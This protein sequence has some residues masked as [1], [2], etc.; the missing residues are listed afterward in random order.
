MNTSMTT[1]GDPSPFRF[2][3]L[4]VATGLAATA[5]VAG[6][7]CATGTA[8]AAPA[9]EPDVVTIVA[10]DRSGYVSVPCFGPRHSFDQDIAGP[11]PTC[12][13]RYG[14]RNLLGNG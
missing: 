1:T 8:A 7:F 3:G 6:L 13:V 5:A 10:S 9:R 2:W 11:P 4:T 14:A 12:Y